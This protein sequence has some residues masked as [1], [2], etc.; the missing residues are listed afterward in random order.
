[1]IL[2][3]YSALP[4]RMIESRQQ[5]APVAPFDKPSGLWVSVAGAADWPSWCRAEEF[6]LERLA[7]CTRIEL[8]P[9]ARLAVIDTPKQMRWLEATYGRDARYPTIGSLGLMIDWPAVAAD[10]QAIVIAPYHWGERLNTR[11]YYPWDCASG[12]IWDADAVASFTPADALSGPEIAKEDG[13]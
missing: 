3:H 8:C 6:G 4:L 1:M 12:C 13:F 2:E 10:W 9:G 7:H 11:W 5:R